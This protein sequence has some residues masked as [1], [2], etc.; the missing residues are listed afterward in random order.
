MTGEALH[1][2]RSYFDEMYATCDDP[3]GFET[4]WYERRKYA[5]TLAMLPRQRYSVAFEPGCANGALTLLLQARC[6]R[7]VACELVAG[8]VSRARERL[9]R[10]R[11][12]DVREGAFPDWWPDDEVDLL[13]LSEIAYYLTPAG[14]RRAEAAIADNLVEGGDLVAVHYTGLTNYP[15]RGIDV[16]R[17]ID[18]LPW[19][20]PIARHIDRD[21]EIGV[22]RRRP[23]AGDRERSTEE[24]V[25]R[26]PATE[27]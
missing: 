2:D 26:G 13:V 8:T 19:L 25:G 5:I 6:D 15:M 18:G 14:L 20:E 7:L 10:H 21:F 24:E 1:H 27:V 4:R 3:W 16:T 23:P 9:Q 22:W 12:V 11:H 17:W